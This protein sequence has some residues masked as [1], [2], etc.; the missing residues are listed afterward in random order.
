MEISSDKIWNKRVE[1]SEAQCELVARRLLAN[2][3]E[4]L[5]DMLGLWPYTS[6][7]ADSRTLHRE[8]ER[9]SA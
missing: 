9:M 8:V 2:G 6:E 1:L 4:D 7:C 3:D 5:L